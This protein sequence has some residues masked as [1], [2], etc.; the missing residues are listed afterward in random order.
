MQD[1]FG[2]KIDYLRLSVTDRCDFRCTYCLPRSHR[3]FATPQSWLSPAELARLCK[4]FCD[5]GIRH[6]RLTGGEPLV[7]PE[8]PEI[9]SKLGRL[10][11]LKELSLSTNASRMAKFADQLRHAGVTRLNISLDSLDPKRFQEL[12]GGELQKVIDGIDAARAAGFAPLKINMVMMRGV[13][14]HEVFDMVEFCRDRELTLRLIETMPVGAG[15]MQAQHNYLPLSEVEQQLRQRYL[16]KEAA[17][18]G[19]GP[20]RYFQLDG[21]KLRIGFITPKSQHFCATCNRVRL[22]VQGVLYLC[23][24]QE[25]KVELGSMMR[26]GADDRQLQAAILEGLANKP[27]RHY[28]NETPSAVV[29]P[30]SALGG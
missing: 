13:N 17:M 3:G 4:V 14:D 24:G 2:R 30:M 23:L 27:E 15:G 12:T 29:R 19:S 9:A 7:R 5:L 10:P 18:H 21:S 25:H 20:A 6:I 16:L 1:G 8:L 26:R 22:S 11:G 28:F